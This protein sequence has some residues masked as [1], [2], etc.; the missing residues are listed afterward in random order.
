MNAGVWFGAAVFFAFG[1][2]P[3]ATSRPMRDLIGTANFPYY[4]EAIGQIVATRF[5]HLYST[6][7]VLAL[8]YLMA[9]WLYFGK[10]PPRRWLG[11]VFAL[12]LF[13]LARGY[14]MQPALKKLHELSHGRAVPIEQREAAARGFRSWGLVAK[15]IDLVLATSLA[16]YLWRVGNPSDPMR[17]VSA[18]K[19]RS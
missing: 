17:F 3:A 8:A 5:F 10:Y 6:C 9:E 14:W 16:V 12:V 1:A 19:F 11:F 4:S 7:S 18:N 15:S 13:G 2:E